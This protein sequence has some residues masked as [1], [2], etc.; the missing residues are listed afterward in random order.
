M[1]K[2]EYLHLGCQYDGKV[3]FTYAKNGG[4]VSSK[5]TMHET[6]DKLGNE[7]FEM[8]NWYVD[9]KNKTVD[10]FFKRPKE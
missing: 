5:E 4:A 10:F 3:Y 7:G 2:W 8:V 9:P 6:L 1:T